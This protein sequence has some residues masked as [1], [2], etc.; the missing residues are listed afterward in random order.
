MTVRHLGLNLKTMAWIDVMALIQGMVFVMLGLV[1]LGITL[2]PGLAGA[3]IEQKPDAPPASK[4][5]LRLGRLQGLV[6]LLAGA[7]MLT[8]LLTS[9][10][11]M[12]G[13]HAP[14]VF[15][16]I[17]VVFLLQ[18]GLNFL[19]WQQ[20][21]ELLRAMIAQTSAVSFWVLQG[22]LFLAASAQKLGLM[23]EFSLWTAMVIT[24]GVYSIASLVVAVRARA[25]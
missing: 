2:S 20:A 10:L 1:A 9:Q 15:A 25:C 21:D 11:G 17:A 3:Q 12:A 6:L 4:R 8:P 13:D 22:A 16:G 23:P 7:L 14:L 19:V 18:S 5:E 24:L